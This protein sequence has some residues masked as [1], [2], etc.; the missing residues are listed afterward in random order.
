MRR[1]P[2][3]QKAVLSCKSETDR[4]PKQTQSQT[5]KIPLKRWSI[6]PHLSEN[7]SWSLHDRD[8]RMGRQENCIPLHCCHQ[9]G[10]QTRIRTK[11][12]Q[13]LGKETKPETEKQSKQKNRA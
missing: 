12:A 3:S 13:G 11:V 9:L 1:Q 6:I 8:Y 5:S 2:R 4:K 10:K 7:K